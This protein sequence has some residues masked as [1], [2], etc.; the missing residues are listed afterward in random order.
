M[1]LYRAFGQKNIKKLILIDQSPTIMSTCHDYPDFVDSDYLMH[2]KQF[3]EFTCQLANEDKFYDVF[4][5]HFENGFVSEA[6]K[7]NGVLD[8][9]LNAIPA[10]N[11]LCLQRMMVV[12][13]QL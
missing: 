9:W 8:S 3:Y 11:Y 6:S 1:E 13:R 12:S 4:C 2:I 7:K 5:K 10:M